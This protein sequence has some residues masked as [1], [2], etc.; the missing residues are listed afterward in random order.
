MDL[1]LESAVLFWFILSDDRDCLTR[2]LQGNGSL[3][4]AGVAEV[5][6]VNLERGGEAESLEVGT[7]LQPT[8]AP[9]QELWALP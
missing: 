6:T 5:N 7:R 4:M 8:Q 1:G 3:L 2:V 9:A